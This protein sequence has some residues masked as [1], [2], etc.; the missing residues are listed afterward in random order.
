MLINLRTGEVL[1]FSQWTDEEI[2]AELQD[3]EEIYRVAKEARD[4]AKSTILAR[5][6]QDGAKLR[7]TDVAKVRVQMTT[8]RARDWSRQP[9]FARHN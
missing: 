9:T 2:L 8:G 7:M 4:M 5:M 1:D 6:E 3:L